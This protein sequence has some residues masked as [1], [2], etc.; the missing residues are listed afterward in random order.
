MDVVKKL[1]YIFS[2]KQKRE[3]LWLFIIICIGS[4]LELMGVSVILPVIDGIMSPDRLLEEPIYEWIYQTFHFTNMKPLISLLL[5]TLI[6]VYVVK[7]VF[8]IYM[9][10]RQ[11]RFIFENQRV[12]ADR[13]MK[14]YMSQPYLYPKT[15]RNC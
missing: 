11:Y 5:I 15:A 1:N 6:V 13:M 9:Y 4:A 3:V 10:N 14:C 8:L 2:A 7:N 12:L